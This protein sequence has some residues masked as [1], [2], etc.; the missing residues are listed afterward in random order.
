M[1]DLVAV[2]RE[3]LGACP[4]CGYGITNDEADAVGL[5]WPMLVLRNWQA[6]PPHAHAIHPSEGTDTGEGKG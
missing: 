3:A 2:I 5:E 6:C 4:I 1:I